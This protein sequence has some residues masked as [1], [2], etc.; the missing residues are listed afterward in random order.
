MI[1]GHFGSI[2]ASFGQKTLPVVEFPLATVAG[3]PLP[4]GATWSG[5]ASPRPDLRFTGTEL[6][7]AVIK[8]DFLNR[9][10]PL[11][12]GLAFVLQSHLLV[13]WQSPI[14]RLRNGATEVLSDFVEK[15]LAGRLGQ[16]L[17][18]LHAHQ[19]GFAFHGH[20]SSVLV[21]QGLPIKNA[22]GQDI[23]IADFLI[24]G[25]SGVRG[26][27]ES[28]ASFRQLTNCPK[29]TKAV[30]R[31]ALGSQV[32]PWMGRLN[33]PVTK[34]YVVAS[35]VRDDSQA[36]TEPSVLAFVD[37]EDTP[38]G[39]DIQV[40][41]A[42]LR[43]ENYAAWLTAMGLTDTAVRLLKR[44]AEG[45]TQVPFIVFEIAGLEFAFPWIGLDMWDCIPH[46]HSLRT[47][48]G[49]MAFGLEVRVLEAIS[50]S[51]RGDDAQLS[52][53]EPL[54]ESRLSNSE[55]YSYSIFPDKTFLGNFD[56]RRTER[57]IEVEL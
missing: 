1:L 51:I 17:S 44:T 18:I 37:P 7:H 25:G 6:A 20:L 55:N 50:A 3:K 54:G 5:T 52:E 39:G 35:Y 41:S 10:N 42:E 9:V 26:L 19:E 14:L 46:P 13:D 16:G 33:P 28:K 53:I 30:L 38:D 40:S 31:K 45:S 4:N 57:I 29:A 27:L 56:R 15:S 36:G 2:I 22:K 32:S 23:P 48:P 21:A 12:P 49:Y 43:R 34:A 8:A 11:M 47:R 24:E